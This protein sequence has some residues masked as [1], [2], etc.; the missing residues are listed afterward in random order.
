MGLPDAVKPATSATFSSAA[1]AKSTSAPTQKR[2]LNILDSE[3]LR[4]AQQHPEEYRTLSVRVVGYS[5][6]FTAL[7]REVQDDIIARTAHRFR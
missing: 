7:S 5:A 1:A 2:Q 4:Q 6:Y 3:L